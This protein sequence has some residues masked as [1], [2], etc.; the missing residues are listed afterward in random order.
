MGLEGKELGSYRFLEKIGRGG[1]GIV[2]KGV[3]KK[4]GQPVAIKVLSPRFSGNPEMHS[5][6]LNEARLQATLSHPN[7]VNIFDYLE[8]DECACL[9]ME[10]ISGQTLDSML[11]SRGRLTPQEVLKVAEGVLNALSFM[12]R[13]GIV[14]RDIKPSNIMV[15]DTG[16]VKVTDF[17]IARLFRGNPSA[18]HTSGMRVG[19]L[20]YMAPEMI[21]EEQVGPS[22]DIYALGVTLYQ[23]LTGELPFTGATEY[24]IIL[25]HLKKPPLPVR[26]ISADAP[27]LLEKTIIK[28]ISKVPKMRY[29][30][31]VEFLDDIGRVP[32]IRGRRPPIA[33]AIPV[34]A[35]MR[36]APRLT[37]YVE[38]RF[39]RLRDNLPSTKSLFRIACAAA[40]ITVTISGFFLFREY[41][42]G[43]DPVQTANRDIPPVLEKTLENMFESAFPNFSDPA[44][45][46]P[47]AMSKDL[48][49]APFHAD[50]LHMDRFAFHGDRTRDGMMEQVMESI[51]TLGNGVTFE[52]SRGI[53]QDAVGELPSFSES[54]SA[55]PDRLIKQGKNRWSIRK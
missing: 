49:D 38:G 37:S 41:R 32:S 27:P 24:D 20:Y 54:S 45:K 16:V 2:Y 15:M 14:H 33:S 39:T 12:H 13:Q 52:Q 29:P 44:A 53:Q 3:H 6:F 43:V 51:D 55:T 17:G 21:R 9:V 48:P 40:L 4:L 35:V 42:R 47:V 31:A 5:R 26:E 19:T 50:D 36:S 25:A 22:S 7:V 8:D 18:T 1:M 28:A 30:S 46:P 34:R 11:L 10:Y 23:L